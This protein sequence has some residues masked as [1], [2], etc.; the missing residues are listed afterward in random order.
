MSHMNAVLATALVV[1]MGLSCA[2]S[3]TSAERDYRRGPAEEVLARYHTA[4]RQ[5]VRE[6]LAAEGAEAL[7]RD[8]D[9][10]HVL[11]GE[12]AKDTLA[13]HQTT[14][15]AHAEWT[16]SRLPR[17][18]LPDLTGWEEVPL[19]GI[20]SLFTGAN[21]VGSHVDAFFP[22]AFLDA[23]AWDPLR[24]ASIARTVLASRQLATSEFALRALVD[25]VAPPCFVAVDATPDA[26][27][28]AF[29][30]AGEV[31]SIRMRRDD[32]VYYLPTEIRWY[33]LPLPTPPPG[34]SE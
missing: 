28:L 11:A 17:G 3:S 21:L 12:V 10:I 5:A 22:G 15:R 30:D 26:P 13:E 8:M 16:L 9:F 32:R 33:R 24:V 27:H 2:D 18:E 1:S 19:V 20:N 34:Q 23:V 31:F 14:L 6:R 7:T 4:L 29:L 25:S